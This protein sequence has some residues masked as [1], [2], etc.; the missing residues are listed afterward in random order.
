MRRLNVKIIYLIILNKTWAQIRFRKIKDNL[1]KIYKINLAVLP[2]IVIARNRI[3]R[4]RLGQIRQ[5]RC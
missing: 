3:P 1:L 2:F 4:Y 5:L